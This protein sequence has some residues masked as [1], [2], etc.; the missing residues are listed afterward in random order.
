VTTLEKERLIPPTLSVDE[1]DLVRAAQE[2]IMESLDHGRAAHISVDCES[3][4]NPSI[5][6]P[7][8]VLKVVG[9]VLGMMAQGRP[10]V[11]MPTTQEFSTVEAAKYLNVSRPFVIKEI[12][13]GRLAH[14]KVG[15]HRRIAYEDLIAYARAM[16]VDREAALD[17]MAQNAQELGLTY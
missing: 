7:P 15:T 11:L 12:D 16:R 5:A 3:G 6:V 1:A 4:T 17:R 13:A 8:Q 10:I 14:R 2:M 9:Q